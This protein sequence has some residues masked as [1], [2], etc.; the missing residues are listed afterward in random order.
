M[1]DHYLCQKRPV[2]MNPAMPGFLTY[3]CGG[4]RVIVTDWNT[5]M[6][7][8]ENFKQQLLL[9]ESRFNLLAGSRL[10]VAQM[11]PPGTFAANLAGSGAFTFVSHDF[12]SYIH[13]FELTVESD[14]PRTKS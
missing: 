9:V 8:T 6:F 2:M 7:T 3:D 12:G 1:L 13:L 14:S 5:D 4:H 11:G 10:C